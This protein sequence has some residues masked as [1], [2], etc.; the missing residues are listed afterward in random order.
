M[1]IV[2]PSDGGRLLSVE[3]VWQ[4]DGV[5]ATP[6]TEMPGGFNNDDQII[7]LDGRSMAAWMQ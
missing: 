2:R 5:V 6:I 1:T 7:A 4:L 3:S